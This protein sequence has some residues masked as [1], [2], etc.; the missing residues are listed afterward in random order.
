MRRKV[1]TPV[2]HDPTSAKQSIKDTTV[3]CQICKKRAIP[4]DNNRK[5][6]IKPSPLVIT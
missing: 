1:F 3:P 5:R 4:G 6:S 2:N